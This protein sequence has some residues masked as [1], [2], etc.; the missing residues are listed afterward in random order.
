MLRIRRALLS[1]SD[2]TSL[3]ELA[4]KLNELQIEI[5][6]TGGTLKT[7]KEAGLPVKAVSEVTGFPEILDGRVKTLHPHIHGA[8]LARRDKEEHL[9][10]LAQ[11]GITPIDLVVVNLYPFQQVIAQEGTTLEEAIENIDIGGPTMVRAAAKNYQGVG[12]VTNPKRYGEIIVELENHKGALSL[13]T[14]FNLAKEA[15]FHTAQYDLAISEYLGQLEEE[16][17]F[18]EE[19]VLAYQKVQDLRYGENP[20]Q[21]AAF[22]RKKSLEA[23]CVAGAKKLQGK[24]LSYNNLVD[25]E[26]ALGIVKEFS[27][28]AA[29]IIKHTNPCGAACA[30]NI[31]DAYQ[32]AYQADPLSAYG[33]IVG[34]NQEVDKGTAEEMVQTFLEAVV[35]PSYS[36]EALRILAQKPNLRVLEVGSLMEKTERAREYKFIQGGLLVQ[37]ED[38]IQLDN[39]KTVTKRSVSQEELDD[40]LFAWKIVKH[41]KSNAIVLAKNKQTVG[42]GA[43]QM[44]RVESVKIALSKAGE[45]ATGSLLASDAFFPFSDGVEVAAQAGVKAVIQPGGAG[46]DQEVIATADQYNLA[47]IFTGERHFKH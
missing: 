6:S 10:A 37:D 18:P 47:M 19:L 20:Q 22:Y 2:K 38:V 30:D 13:E 8:I 16:L 24:E 36:E 5:I 32:K 33:G 21:K 7:L 28:P 23:P 1:V 35:A 34:L 11:K 15:F 45:K 46:N 27:E 44:S 14:R 4:K 26:A 25:L 31:T 39:L 9:E 12:I 43:G 42:V 41:V 3:V 40:L 29:A 17:E